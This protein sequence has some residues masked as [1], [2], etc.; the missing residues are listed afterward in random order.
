MVSSTT[1][2][3]VPGRIS[4]GA[5]LQVLYGQ[6][7]PHL[8]SACVSAYTQTP[9]HFFFFFVWHSSTKLWWYCYSGH[10]IY[11]FAYKSVPLLVSQV[12]KKAFRYHV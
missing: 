4:M 3:A 9:Y 2:T 11:P 12:S 6:V 8:N 1:N 5:S 7:N 10:Y